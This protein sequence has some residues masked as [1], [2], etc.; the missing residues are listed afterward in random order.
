MPGQGVS[1][2]FKFGRT[3][4]QL[5]GILAGL[6]VPTFLVRPAVWKLALGLTSDKYMS[7]ELASKVFPEKKDMWVLKKHNDRAEA[8]LLAYYGIRKYNKIIP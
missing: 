3:C 2:T 5:Q 7:M 6:F 1:S 4:G 8:A